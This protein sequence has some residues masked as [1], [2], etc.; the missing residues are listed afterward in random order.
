MP[1]AVWL[2]AVA[3]GDE[4]VVVGQAPDEV[5]SV[6][7]SGEDRPSPLTVE[8]TGQG[9]PCD[10][11]AS[12]PAPAPPRGTHPGGEWPPTYIP[13]LVQLTCRN[14]IPGSSPAAWLIRA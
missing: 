4:L 2:G 1:E 9:R 7:R 3:V 12:A 11:P 10:A 13:L 6:T 14:Q 8:Q 5:V